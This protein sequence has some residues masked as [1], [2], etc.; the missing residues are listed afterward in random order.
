M[1]LF[2]SGIFGFVIIASLT[3]VFPNIGAAYAVVLK[4]RDPVTLPRADRRR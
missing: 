1:T 4:P 3:V 2:P